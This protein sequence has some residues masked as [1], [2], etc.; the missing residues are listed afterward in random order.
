M[1][2]LIEAFGVDYTQWRA[3]TRAYLFVDHAALFGAF[4]HAASMRA[5]R[6]LLVMTVL[7]G[8]IGGSVAVFVLACRDT[9]LGGT[10]MTTVVG[11]MVATIVMN[12]ASMMAA[13][14][15]YAIVGFRPV[16]SRTYFAVRLTSLLVNT[17][18]IALVSGYVPV[19]AF[20][21]REGG[22]FGLAAAA[23]VAVLATAVAFTFLLMGLYGW[24]IQ[25]IRPSLFTRVAGLMPTISVLIVT[26]VF[27]VAT[28]QFMDAALPGLDLMEGFSVTGV[29]LP[30][31]A[32]MLAYPPAWFASYVEIA[33]GTAGPMEQSAALMSLVALAG[34]LV[35]LRGR[36]ST[37][38]AMRLA[39]IASASRSTAPRNATPPWPFLRGERRAIALVFRSQL[40]DDA[41][42]QTNVL[43][44]LLAG[45]GIF[46]TMPLYWMPPDPFVDTSP[47][48]FAFMAV[49]FLAVSFY[50]SLAISQAADATWLFFTT[51][52]ARSRLILAARDITA[53]IVL[54]PA[55]AIL[56][57]IFLH[58]FDHP[59]HAIVHAF[60]IA[61]L[62]FIELQIAVLLKPAVPF[63]LP[64]GVAKP[65]IGFRPFLVGVVPLAMFFGLHFLAYR[66]RLG[67]AIGLAVIGLA[68]AALEHRLRRRLLG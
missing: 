57:G 66:S 61:G 39:Q 51:P 38:F 53:T 29:Q 30:R 33:R 24:F 50:D 5:A 49:G 11:L 43:M 44:T 2:L 25:I 54:A 60:A 17:L 7:F 41:S 32:W 59:G 27:L 28:F 14:D 63:S 6:Q 34:A 21:L 26:A 62:A 19:A 20:L 3:L 40:H 56:L 64:L 48:F 1:K 47:A 4:G 18:A 67:T 55:V 52:G 16:S 10:L 68:I 9:L 31:S 15:D 22:S 12:P 45:A 42:F 36:L 23:A 13:P 58:R 35:I 37:A 65:G 46:I 8:V